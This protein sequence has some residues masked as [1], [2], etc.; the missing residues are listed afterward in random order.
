MRGKPEQSQGNLQQ[1][2]MCN[3]A[4]FT[5]TSKTNERKWRKTKET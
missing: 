5:R 2:C 1:P 4:V 3:T